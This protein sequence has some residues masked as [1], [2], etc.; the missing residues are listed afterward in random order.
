MVKLDFVVA[1]AIKV[2]WSL[3][4]LNLPSDLLQPLCG[5][6]AAGSA[7]SNCPASQPL[8]FH[9]ANHFHAVLV[10]GCVLILKG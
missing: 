6:I 4:N 2:N 3:A 9:R 1:T 5:I 10:R 7:D 8:S